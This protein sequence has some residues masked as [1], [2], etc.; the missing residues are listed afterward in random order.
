MVTRTASRSLHMGT[1]GSAVDPVVDDDVGVGNERLDGCRIDKRRIDQL[2]AIVEHRHECAD[3]SSRR[4][5]QE[6][7]VGR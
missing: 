1:P 5:G 4:A 2:L 3:P 7:R 6:R